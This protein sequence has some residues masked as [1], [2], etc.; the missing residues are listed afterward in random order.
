MKEQVTDSI[1]QEQMLFMIRKTSDGDGLDTA[2]QKL[3]DSYKNVD[4]RRLK[5]LWTMFDKLGIET[6]EK[7][8]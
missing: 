3:K 4:N 1:L 6:P 2:T 8:V 7:I 5:K